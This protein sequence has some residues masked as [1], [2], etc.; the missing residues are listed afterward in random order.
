MDNPRNMLTYEQ[1][2]A[3]SGLSD[4]WLRRLASAGVLRVIRLGHRT[5]LIRRDELERVVRLFENKPTVARSQ[6]M[7]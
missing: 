5:V 4:S 2:A 1:A 6:L 3:E 7:A